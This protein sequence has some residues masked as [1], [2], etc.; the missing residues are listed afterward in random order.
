M[1]QDVEMKELPAAPSNSAASSTPST[2]HHLKEIA[3][4]IE[5]G[6][7]A[8]EVRRIVRAVRLTMAL[9]K[10]LKASVLSAFLNFALT[11]G[12]EP[13]NRLFS[14]LPKVKFR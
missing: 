13:H 12:S 8:R 5:T 2:L 11:P 7:Y 6:A 1:T 10:K 9:R 4:L 14:Y 3:A